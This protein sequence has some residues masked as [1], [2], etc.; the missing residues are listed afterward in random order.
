MQHRAG[1]KNMK[2]FFSELKSVSG[3]PPV[4]NADGSQTFTDILNCW[5]EYFEDIHR[6]STVT[7]RPEEVIKQH[8]IKEDLNAVPTLEELTS[9]P[10]VLKLGKAPED[11]RIPPELLKYGEDRLK[12]RLLLF[13]QRCW[14]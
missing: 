7:V 11:N 10:R 1:T 8:P 2:A 9:V 3:Q 13:F 5:K 4:K 14:V 6:P 12:Q